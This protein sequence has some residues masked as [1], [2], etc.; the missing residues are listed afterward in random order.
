MNYHNFEQGP[1]RPPSEA[2]SLLLRV[3]RNCTWNKCKFCSLYKGES[4]SVR[5]VEELKKDIDE[6][7]ESGYY[8]NCDS[9]FLQDA[10]SI[11]L[12]P[13]KTIEVL[14]YLRSKFPKIKRITTYGRADTLSKISAEEYDRLFAAGLN[15]IHSGYESGSDN[16]LKLINKGNTKEQEILAGKKIKQSG[17]QL[18]I[19]FMPGVGGREYSTENAIETADVINQV[20]PDFV[21]IRT[22]IALPG[23]GIQQDIDAGTF[24][25]CTDVEKAM[26]VKHLIENITACDGQIVSDHIINLFEDVKGNLATQKDKLLEPFKEFEAMN[27]GEQERFQVARRTGLVRIMGEMKRISPENKDK[28][29][30]YVAYAKEMEIEIFLKKLLRRY[31]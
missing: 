17:I 11:V 6:M 27:L 16:V 5:T 19:Y 21:R 24:T 1:I 14:N 3:T 25:E 2:N 30:E 13:D 18:S 10:N 4:F 23:S 7:A 20:N 9:A 15:R 28:L 29:D 8:D 12:S 22:F 26:E 31:I